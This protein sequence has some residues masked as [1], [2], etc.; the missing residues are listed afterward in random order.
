M[1]KDREID[2]LG[3]DAYTV[4]KNFIVCLLEESI[5]MIGL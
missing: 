3:Y 1:V 2:S 4:R 5:K